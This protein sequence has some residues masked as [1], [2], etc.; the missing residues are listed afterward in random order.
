LDPLTRKTLQQWLLGIQQSPGLT[1]VMVTHDVEEALLLGDRVALMSQ[2]PG[3][4]SRT[5]PLPSDARE[6]GRQPELRDEVLR[7]YAEVASGA[8]VMPS[9]HRTG[10]LN[11]IAS[12]TL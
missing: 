8:G 1:V 12:S 7:A 9:G 4:R 11:E 6:R 5:W 2:S 10:A 3:R